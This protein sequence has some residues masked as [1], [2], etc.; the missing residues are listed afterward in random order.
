MKTLL[1]FA[2]AA[3]LLAP[4]ALA[5]GCT[6]CAASAPATVTI[7]GST[8]TIAV[9]RIEN[10]VPIAV[11]TALGCENCAAHAVAFALQQ[12][13]TPEEIERALKVL[14]SM[15]NL[16]CFKKQFGPDAVSRIEKPLAAARKALA[17]AAAAR[18][19]K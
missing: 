6:A 5:Q 3:L 11:T 19:A 12:G 14:A 7:P 9:G 4:A 13:S 15:Q 8:E 18:A 10:L 16:D 17:D 2:A 1:L